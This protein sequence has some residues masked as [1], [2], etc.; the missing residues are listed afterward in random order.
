M[1]LKQKANNSRI[2]KKKHVEEDMNSFKSWEHQSATKEVDA[3]GI[4]NFEQLDFSR[5]SK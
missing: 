5:L 3:S 4:S 1:V 2:K